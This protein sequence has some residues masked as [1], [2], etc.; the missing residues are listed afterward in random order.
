MSFGR[1]EFCAPLVSVLF[2]ASEAHN[3]LP[4]LIGA[5]DVITE[6]THFQMTPNSISGSQCQLSERVADFVPCDSDPDILGQSLITSCGNIKTVLHNAIPIGPTKEFSSFDC[7]GVNHYC[8][9]DGIK[10]AAFI[11]VSL[12]LATIKRIR[13]NYFT[14]RYGTKQSHR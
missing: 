2:A 14:L 6:R 13:A 5:Y 12:A 8:P 4:P 7:S 1:D 10:R 11:K 9:A 3:K